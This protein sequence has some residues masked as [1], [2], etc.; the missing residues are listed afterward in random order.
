MNQFVILNIGC[1]KT[2]IP[3]SIGIDRASIEGF[4]DIVHNLDLVPYP[5]QD[6]SVDEIHLYHVLEHL[7]NPVKIMEEI[8]RILK[9]GGMLYMRVPHFSSMGAFSDITHKRPFGYTSF[10]CFQKGALFNYYSQVE[11]EFVKKRLKYF[12]QYPNQGVYAK[13]IHPNTCPFPVRPFVHLMNFLMN[14]SPVFFERFWCYW[15]GGACEVELEMRKPA[16]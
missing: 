8:H 12:G 5:F 13:H 2:R 6:A 9:P 11:F 16:V 7:E 14:L 4:T 1:G 3:G 10:D 15:F